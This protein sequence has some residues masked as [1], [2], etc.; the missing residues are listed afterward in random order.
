M[1]IKKKPGRLAALMNRNPFEGFQRGPGQLNSEENLQA[2][3]EFDDP[4]DEFIP[5]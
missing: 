4:M 2:W 5:D 1:E 3:E